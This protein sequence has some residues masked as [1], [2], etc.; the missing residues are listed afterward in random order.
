MHCIYLAGIGPQFPSHSSLSPPQLPPRRFSLGLARNRRSLLRGS[1]CRQIGI[2]RQNRAL[3]LALGGTQLST[4]QGI[5]YPLGYS[6]T[7][8]MHFLLTKTPGGATLRSAGSKVLAGS[9]MGP[10]DPQTHSAIM[11]QFQR[12]TCALSSFSHLSAPREE[13]HVPLPPL[14][15]R[16]GL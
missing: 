2:S 9:Q 8:K 11:L 12:S 1:P 10:G 7:H 13:E 16:Q 15:W 5:F 14:G 4:S 6:C 3:D